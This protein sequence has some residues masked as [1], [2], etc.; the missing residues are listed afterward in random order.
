VSRNRVF[1]VLVVIAIAILA[2]IGERRGGLGTG[3]LNSYVAKYGKGP[4]AAD[5]ASLCKGVKAGGGK[6]AAC[7]EQHMGEL[8]PACK[9]KKEAEAKEEA[10]TP[11]S[12][13]EKARQKPQPTPTETHQP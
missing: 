1:L 3:L 8:S 13:R 11:P 9:A 10:A 5:R 4:C 7:L 6:I 2:V 12:D